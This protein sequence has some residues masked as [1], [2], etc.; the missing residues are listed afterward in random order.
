V[1]A[2]GIQRAFRQVGNQFQKEGFHSMK[3][4]FTVMCTLAVAFALALPVS[5]KTSKSKKSETSTTATTKAHSK[6]SKKFWKKGKKSEKKGE[7]T[8]KS[9]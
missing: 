4:L 2:V 6:H 7:K 9:K 5:A 1:S 8:G 3:K